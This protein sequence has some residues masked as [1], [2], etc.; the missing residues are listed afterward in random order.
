[1]TQAIILAIPLIIAFIGI[2]IFSAKPNKKHHK[3][4][5]C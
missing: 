3:N 5:A 4:D 2:A 1:M